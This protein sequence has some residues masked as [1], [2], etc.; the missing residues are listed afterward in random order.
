MFQAFWTSDIFNGG[1][2][3]GFFFICMAA[4]IEKGV[5]NFC[6]PLVVNVVGG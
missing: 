6:D 5:F 4:K 2:P 3:G 1:A